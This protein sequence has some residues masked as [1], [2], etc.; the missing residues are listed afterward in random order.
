SP[1][2]R[3]FG[4]AEITLLEQHPLFA[5]TPAA[6]PVWMSHGDRIEA[7]PAGFR[8]IA[9]NPSTPF[10]AM[11]DDARRWFGVQFHPEVVHT[12]HGRTILRNFLFTVCGATAD[13]RPA[14]FVADAI[15]RVREQVGPDGRVVCAL[16][17]GV[18]SAVAALIIH[19]A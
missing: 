10:A 9:A 6:Q 2:S 14:G 12:A 8:A 18:D 7:L 19:R 13:W 17:G 3:E 16:S 1:E 5:D 11:A 15:E 4:P